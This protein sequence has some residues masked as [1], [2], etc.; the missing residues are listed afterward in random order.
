M[1]KITLPHGSLKEFANPLTVKEL[2]TSLAISLGKRTLGAIV[3]DQMRSYDYLITSDAN[4]KLV[5][6]SDP[7]GWQIINY[8]AGLLT[9]KALVNLDPA[10]KI[11]KIGLNDDGFYVDFD[12][13]ISVKETDL[14]NIEQTTLQLIQ[15]NI[16]ITRVCSPINDLKKIYQDNSYV[17]DLINNL[18]PDKSQKCSYL[19]DDQTYVYNTFAAVNTKYVKAYK[20]LSLAGAYWQDDSKNKMLQRIYGSAHL[21]KELF[22]E[23]LVMLAERKERDHRKIGKDLEIFT[24]DKL[25]GPGLPIWLPNGMSLKRAIQDFIRE[26]EWEYDFIEVDTPVIGTSEMY[27][28]SGHWDHYKENMFPPMVQDHEVSVLRPMSCPHHIAIYN[29]KPRSYRELPLRLAEHAIM[30]RYESSGSLTG[31]ER[32]RMMQLTDSHIFVRNDQIKE[33]FKRC[34]KLINETLTA[35]N[36]EVDYYSLSLRDVNDKEKYYDDDEMWDHAERMLQEALDELKIKY[37]PMPGEAAFYGPKLDIQIK[38]ALNH[39]ITVSTLQFDFLLPQKFNLS[40]IDQ[41]G[42]K[43]TPTIIHRGLIGTYERFIAILLEQTKGVLPLWLAPRQIAI[44]PVNETHFPYAQEIYQ[45]L[46]TLKLRTFIDFRDERLS[47]K[48]RDA[49]VSKIPYQLVLGD[50]EMNDNTITYRLYGQE[51]QVTVG[52]DEFIILLNNRINSRQ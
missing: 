50:N 14:D 15:N 29:S 44:I 39:E 38:T 23:F 47:Y 25:V 33:E 30:H 5:L 20:I 46:K 34:F 22:S 48:I 27:K 13:E 21:S 35:F 45:K 36:I 2:A 42:E 7:E 12:A 19:L 24:F 28:I 1:I 3:N 10:I 11:A 43:A 17:L 51:D 52:F 9:A 32:V 31:L 37:V 40:Y 4:I 49:Q 26:K 16:K 41:N 8:T 6:E 18:P